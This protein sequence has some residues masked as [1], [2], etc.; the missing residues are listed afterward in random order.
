MTPTASVAVAAKVATAPAADVASIVWLAGSVSAGAVVS[1]TLMMML[2][3]AVLPAASVAERDTEAK[4]IPNVLPEGGFAITGTLLLTKSLAVATN[5]TGAP[6]ALVASAVAVV[7]AEMTGGV[8]SR[9]VTVNEL[10]AAL[11][12][13]SL[14]LRCTVVTPS[15]NVLPEAG[16][17]VTAT[18]PSTL[19]LAV[20]VKLTTAPDGLVAST[21]MLAGV[22]ITG[23]VVSAVAA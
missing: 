5:V 18:A 16:L 14:A 12:A 23:G 13:A 6:A 10:W 2:P 8:V 1:R 15:G 9:T 3:E 4:P 19:S 22:A 7:G 11:P 17:A 20:A 21:V